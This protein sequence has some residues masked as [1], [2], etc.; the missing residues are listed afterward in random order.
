MRQSLF[1]K[2]FG[3]LHL[4][5]GISII[6]ECNGIFTKR[7]NHSLMRLSTLTGLLLLFTSCLYE[8]TETIIIPNDGSSS[9]TSTT[10]EEYAIPLSVQAQLKQYIS[11]YEGGTPP[12]VEGT[13]LMSKTQTVYCSDNG[14]IPGYI[15]DDITIKFS[16]QLS[17]RNTL[18]YEESGTNYYAYGNDVVIIGSGNNFTT[19]FV[20]NGS[21]EGVS[22]KQTLVIS[23]TLTSSGIRNLYYAFVMIDKGSDPTNKLMNVDEY[24]IFKDSDGL[25]ANS[26]WNKSAAIETNEN[27]PVFLPLAIKNNPENN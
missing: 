18:K 25:A 5:K 21:I 12:V 16:N 24:R 11:I 13:Y 4:G 27:A 10:I 19:Y 26:S 15:I 6:K 8:G 2:C 20:S 3:Y 22:Y 17:Q 23:G 9:G 1:F 7:K 14:Y